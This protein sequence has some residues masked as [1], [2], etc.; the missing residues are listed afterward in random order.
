MSDDTVTEPA[1]EDVPMVYVY[2]AEAETS[3]MRPMT[4]E[5]IAAQVELD[6]QAEAA[7]SAFEEQATARAAAREA[8][9]THAESLGFTPEMI[10]VMFPGLG[11]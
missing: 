2:D 7:A 9:V 3:T 8:A 5:E 6:G 4:G 11:A 1:A 10:A